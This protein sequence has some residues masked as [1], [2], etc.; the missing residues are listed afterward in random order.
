MK[1][2]YS[3]AHDK[4]FVRTGTEKQMRKQPILYT[5]SDQ[6][7]HVSSDTSTVTLLNISEKFCLRTVRKRYLHTS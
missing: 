1:S 2:H 5:V 3:L 7:L 4:Y 6:S